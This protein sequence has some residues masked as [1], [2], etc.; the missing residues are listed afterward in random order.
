MKFMSVII[1]DRDSD[2]VI[3][4]LV[5]N[6]Y[7]V[8]RMS[9][10]GGFLRQGNVTLLLGLEPQQVDPVIALLRKNCTS[11]DPNRHAA[12]IFVLEMPDYLKV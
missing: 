3:E 1:Q 5:Q 12:T 7:A 6:G 9:S 8:T 2:R 10:T 4:S 11:T